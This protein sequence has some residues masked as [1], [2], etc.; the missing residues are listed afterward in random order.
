MWTG[1][2]LLVQPQGWSGEAW[3]RRDPSWCWISIGLFTILLPQVQHPRGFAKWLAST[4]I[5][6]SRVNLPGFVWK[7][8]NMGYPNQSQW[9]IRL[10][11]IFSSFF[12]LKSQSIAIIS[13]RAPHSWNTHFQ[14]YQLLGGYPGTWGKWMTSW[15][16]SEELQRLYTYIIYIYIYH[17]I[18]NINI[19]DC[20][21]KRRAIVRNCLYV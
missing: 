20:R 9:F 13:N 10:S 2:P 15:R 7:Y 18:I 6:S 3:E 14:P 1:P 8:L 11:H 5:N 17:Y 12:Q 19:L 16:W 21:K 4:C